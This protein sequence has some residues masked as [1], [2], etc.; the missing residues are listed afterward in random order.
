MKFDR[1]PQVSEEAPASEI[2]SNG[3]P[4]TRVAESTGPSKQEL[5]SLRPSVH[6]E[7][8]KEGEWVAR[9]LVFIF[10]SFQLH[11]YG[12]FFF[13]FC[14]IVFLCWIFL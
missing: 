7:T 8:C 9:N 11:F 6:Q 2:T 3:H 5:Q 1:Y 12:G 13:F 4:E 14:A 10:L